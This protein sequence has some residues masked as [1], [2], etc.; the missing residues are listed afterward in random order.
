MLISA[1]FGT[2]KI[3]RYATGRE[4]VRI[5]ITA[6]RFE[7]MVTLQTEKESRSGIYQNQWRTYA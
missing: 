3:V 1:T 6:N 5:M 4:V 7:I 2:M